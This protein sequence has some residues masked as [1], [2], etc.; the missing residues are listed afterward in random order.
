MMENNENIIDE[1]NRADEE[2]I[3]K[4][5]PLVRRIVGY[6]LGSSFPNYVED[7]VQKVILNLWRWKDKREGLPLSEEE[8]QKIANRAAQNEVKMLYRQN[9]G[10]EVFITDLSEPDKEF[11]IPALNKT[12]DGNT[13]AE[14]HSLLNY[15]WITIQELSTRQRYALLFQKQELIVYLLTGKCCK[16][17]ELAEFLNLSKETL[18]GIIR[19]LPYS[20]EQICDFFRQN[21]NEEVTPKQIWE[22]R[23]KARVKIAA[24]LK[25]L[26]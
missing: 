17:N 15:V 3:L 21:L 19:A 9:L 7:I 6:R 26:D 20:D 25:K 10:R 12:A 8:W 2:H 1:K 4:T 5:V 11:E 13:E 24:A 18:L 22:A 23:G 14:S 16:L